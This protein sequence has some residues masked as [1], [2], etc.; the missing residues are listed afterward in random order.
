MF[1]A[2]LATPVM[3]M[4]MENAALEAMKPYFER[5]RKRGGHAVDVSQ[6]G[7]PVG[8]RIV[9]HAEVTGSTAGKSRSECMRWTERTIGGGTHD[10]MVID[11]AR[12]S[13][14]F[15]AQSRNKAG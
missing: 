8:R 6:L 3:I 13:E 1:P 11:L 9:A 15:A 10:R 14:R 7:L 5:G 12:F 4:A 2:V